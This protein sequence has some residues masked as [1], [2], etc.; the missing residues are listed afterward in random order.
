MERKPN[1]SFEDY[2]ARRTAANLVTKNINR[3]A[4]S[5]GTTS[6]RE[7]LRRESKPKGTYG[8]NIL[9]MFARQRVTPE[10]LAKHAA[11]LKHA[12]NRKAKRIAVALSASDFIQ[13]LA[14]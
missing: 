10:R 14:A 5:G 9:A 6:T 13:P 3:K 11:H 8:L 12:A 2:K 7:K 1:E 4:R